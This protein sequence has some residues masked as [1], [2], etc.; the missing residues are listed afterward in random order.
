MNQL[1]PPSAD[2]LGL[3]EQRPGE[4]TRHYWSRFLDQKNKILD[5]PDAEEI[6]AF[7]HNIRDERL[8][9][10][11][12]K[13]RPR[14]MSALTHLMTR[15]CA[16]ENGWVTRGN[17]NSRVLKERNADTSPR[18]IMCPNNPSTSDADEEAINV[19]AA[20]QQSGSK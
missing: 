17:R 13:E 19:V 15:Y 7:K 3:I 14:S 16:G 20:H 4:S 18:R 10:E 5:C 6:A 11:L 12:R 9:R 2:D 8:A 1:Q